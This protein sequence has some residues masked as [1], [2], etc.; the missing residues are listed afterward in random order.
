MEIR[1]KK[2]QEKQLRTI[3]DEKRSEFFIAVMKKLLSK[4]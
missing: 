2:I 4:S 1:H 3:G